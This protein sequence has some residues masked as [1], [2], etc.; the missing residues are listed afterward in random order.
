MQF[1]GNLRKTYP[2]H[3]SWRH[4]YREWQKFQRILLMMAKS[5][6]DS[7]MNSDQLT[8]FMNVR[9]ILTAW[10]HRTQEILMTTA[11]D[12]SDTCSN[13]RNLCDIYGDGSMHNP[14][15]SINIDVRLWNGRRLCIEWLLQWWQNTLHQQK[16]C[17][18]IC[19]NPFLIILTLSHSLQSIITMINTVWAKQGAN[20]SLTTNNYSST[21][22]QHTKTGEW[23]W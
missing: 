16:T 1:H 23:H 10:R 12:L 17:A 2:L 18:P 7:M 14:K 22:T 9:I 4:I 13:G 20:N 21:S 15:Y 8:Q 3:G 5:L 11:W 19:N 6:P